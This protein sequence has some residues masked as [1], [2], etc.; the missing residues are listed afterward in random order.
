MKGYGTKA[1][2]RVAQQIQISIV[3]NLREVKEVRDWNS[4]CRGVNRTEAD[5]FNGYYQNQRDQ[6]N[7]RRQKLDALNAADT[8][9]TGLQTQKWARTEPSGRGCC[10]D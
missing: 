7:V 8:L 6:A 10:D 1:A 4:L 9:V 2:L 5:V 3:L